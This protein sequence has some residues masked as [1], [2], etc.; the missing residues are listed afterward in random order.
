[1]YAY[2]CES[3]SSLKLEN[4]DGEWI[5]AVKASEIQTDLLA[6]TSKNQSKAKQSF[7]DDP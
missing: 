6:Q 7:C 1:M 2:M 3:I 5:I 4:W